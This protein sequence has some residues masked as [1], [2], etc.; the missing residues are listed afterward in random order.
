MLFVLVCEVV[1]STPRAY[2]F[3]VRHFVF[4]SSV[5]R[6]GACDLLNQMLVTYSALAFGCLHARKVIS[7][8]ALGKSFESLGAMI[9]LRFSVI[10]FTG[11]MSVRMRVK[12]LC[13][14]H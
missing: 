8:K 10:V 2:F 1:G 7:G 5:E 13:C 12:A 6:I 3:G 14:S 11:T 4:R 9:D